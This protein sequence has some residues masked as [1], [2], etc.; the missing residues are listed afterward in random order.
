[1][2][3]GSSTPAGSEEN[4]E[5]F[6]DGTV[7][8]QEVEEEENKHSIIQE[9]RNELSP[10]G[11]SSNNGFKKSESFAS[12]RSKDFCESMEDLDVSPDDYFHDKEWIQKRKHIFILSS[13]G[14]P[15][16]SLHENEGKLATL[17]GTLQALVSFVQANND[18]I[19]S[20]VADGIKFVF[21]IRSSL[22][23]VAATRDNIA[24]QQLQM[25]LKWVPIVNTLYALI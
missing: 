7:D 5:D 1:M 20:I 10:E 23:L 21:L 2:E 16:Y 17:C 14:K 12:V 19:T 11:A 9:I 3:T 15:I 22:I 6:S 25:Q 13:A 18:T 8:Y 24:V 4:F